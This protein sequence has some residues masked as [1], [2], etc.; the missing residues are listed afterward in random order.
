MRRSLLALAG[1]VAVVGCGSS[2]RDDVHRTV[3]VEVTSSPSGLL[4]GV[5]VGLD[6][7]FEAQTPIARNVRANLGFCTSLTAQGLLECLVFAS[8]SVKSGDP[9]GKR[10]TMCLTDAGERDCAT[11]HDGTVLV[12]M[13]VQVVD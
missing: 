10:V 3:F 2:D 7:D 8:A 13:T 5:S 1:L 4:M 9:A 6:V 11:S 12:S